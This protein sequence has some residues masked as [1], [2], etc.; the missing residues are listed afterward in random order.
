[1]EHHGDWR[2]GYDNPTVRENA[3]NLVAWL[4]E[5]YGVNNPVRHRDVVDRAAYPGGTACPG[6]LPVESIWNRSTEIINF[7]NQP[8]TPVD[9]RPEW[10]KNRS[11]VP[12]RMVY[13][14]REGIFVHN[15]SDPDQPLDS[16]RFALNQ[17]FEIKGQTVAG[18]KEF[19]ITKSSYDL[20]IGSGLLKSDVADAPFVPPVPQPIPEPPKPTTPDWA[21]SLLVDE[22]NKTMYVLRATPLIDLEYGRPF[23]KDGKEVWFQAG[24]IINDVS[25]HTIVGGITY[26]LTEYS[27]KETIGKRYANANGIQ[28]SDLTVDPKACPPGT[29]ANPEAA[30]EPTDP[31]APMPDVPTPDVPP[32][33]P[34]TEPTVPEP[35]TP[36]VPET[37]A[38]V[39]PPAPP[40]PNALV[41]LL[42]AIFK[43][44]QTRFSKKK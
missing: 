23:V 42:L 32:A 16:R 20:N 8:P 19:W 1:M 15:L 14:Q 33:L 27:F 24:D 29:P 2:F 30:P 36:S 3:A 34:P 21:D 18:G 43:A 13:G 11:E 44:L 35:E 9:N 37:P 17:N 5:N 6:D 28:S 4:R 38:P 10:M 12:G 22:A 7:Y 26:Q 25:A 39:E 41:V 40:K 31:I